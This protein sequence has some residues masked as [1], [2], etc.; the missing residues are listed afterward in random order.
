MLFRSERFCFPVTIQQQ[1]LAQTLNINT[2]DL[3]QMQV[4]IRQNVQSGTPQLTTIIPNNKEQNLSTILNMNTASNKTPSTQTIMNKIAS[5][6]NL[7]NTQKQDFFTQLNLSSISSSDAKTAGIPNNAT[8]IKNAATAQQA[9]QI[10]PSAKNVPSAANLGTAAAQPAAQTDTN[11]SGGDVN[12]G[13]SHEQ[14]PNGQTAM[15]ITGLS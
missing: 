11:G 6:L 7:S 14:S 12:T 15:Q 10:Q 1:Q 9:D 3:K 2:A 8:A 13:G 5:I 4:T